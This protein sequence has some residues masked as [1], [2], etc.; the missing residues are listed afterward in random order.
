MTNGNDPAAGRSAD[1]SSRFPDPFAP[2]RPGTE[3]QG[4]PPPGTPALG[5][6]A[7]G[8]SAHSTPTPRDLP[9]KA[10][11]QRRDLWG[12]VKRPLEGTIH[13]P[14]SKAV[15]MPRRRGR[16]LTVGV[17][18]VFGGT[19]GFST[20][21]VLGVS[22]LIGG[23]G[24]LAPL[25]GGLG[26]AAVIGGGTAYLLRNRKP[27]PARLTI[28]DAQMPEG[29]RALLQKVI[30]TT[31]QQ[32]RRI[33]QVRRRATGSAS[34]PVFARADALLQ[35]I[36]A[37][38]GAE[39]LQSRRPSD[40]DVLM[41][42]GM[43]TRYIPDLLDALEDTVVLLGSVQGEARAKA[44][45]NVDAIDQQLQVI[46][47]GIER[48]EADVVAGVTHSLEVHSEFLRT[49]FSDQRLNPIIDV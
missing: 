33:L 17:P 27:R 12:P 44:L 5:A 29:T 25:L 34:K 9:W 6:S 15:A 1:G 46:G 37:L 35:R 24:L 22:S 39:S 38:L 30:T 4:P 26:V 42:E 40:G 14:R 36:D 45:A 48:I 8:T 19:L 3:P 7:R 10:T 31:T 23:A 32:R 49:R 47:E 28:S 16:W 43:A 41:L 11:G 21:I 18:S 20:F 2:D 13:P